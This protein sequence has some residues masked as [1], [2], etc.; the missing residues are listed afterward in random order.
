MIIVLPLFNPPT[1]D[2]HVED[3]KARRL[4]SAD[5]EILANGTFVWS[6]MDVEHLRKKPSGK[7]RNFEKMYWPAL[8]VPNGSA[9]RACYVALAHLITGQWKYRLACSTSKGFADHPNP[10]IKSFTYIFLKQ[11][12]DAIIQK[13]A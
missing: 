12:S 3:I 10:L 4:S 13:F 7:S 1:K 5:V 11:F 2:I 6:P 8:E 9:P